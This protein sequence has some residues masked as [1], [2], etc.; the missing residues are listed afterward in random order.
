MQLN[1]KQL[2]TTN[3]RNSSG[4]LLWRRLGLLALTSERHAQ[5]LLSHL[6]KVSWKAYFRNN[7]SVLPVSLVQ[8]SSQNQSLTNPH[9]WLRAVFQSSH[10]TFWDAC[11][12]CDFC[13]SGQLQGSAR[14]DQ[15]CRT[16]D[17][18]CMDCCFS[19]L[20][21]SHSQLGA[22]CTKEHSPWGR[23]SCRILLQLVFPNDCLYYWILYTFHHCYV[24]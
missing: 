6:D 20:W 23:M 10:I 17:D 2:V 7:F 3:S 18:D 8:P 24:L 21:A 15:K 11:N 13:P 9:K 1:M 14:D 5:N 12:V 19:P 22:H 4:Y 16:E